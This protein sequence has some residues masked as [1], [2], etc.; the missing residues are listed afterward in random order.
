MWGVCMT[1]ALTVLISDPGPVLRERRPLAVHLG[2]AALTEGHRAALLAALG[3][4]VEANTSLRV[5][6]VDA[7]PAAAEG[8]QRCAKQSTFRCWADVLRGD[9]TEAAPLLFLANGIALEGDRLRVAAF[10]MDLGAARALLEGRT[11]E[12]AEE[13]E[14]QLYDRA[15]TSSV[16]AVRIG[17]SAALAKELEEML[18]LDLAQRL[19]AAGCAYPNGRVIVEA[20]SPGLQIELEGLPV[21]FSATEPTVIDG[22]REGQRA[23]SVQDPK[24]GGPAWTQALAITRGGEVRVRPVLGL[25]EP[26]DSRRVVFWSG[27]GVGTLGLGILAYS[28]LASPKA[29]E[30][31]VCVVC[32]GGATG[33]FAR[34]SDF[35]SEAGAPS[36]PLVGP[37]GYS[38]AAAGGTTALTSLLGAPEDFPWWSIVAGVAAFGLSYS[39]SEALD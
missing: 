35:W 11:G 34:T 10:L 8:S 20:D 13:L 27:I 7:L 38:L 29:T 15:I 19:E 6:L 18:T 23:L 37:L 14:A 30:L 17:D 5:V 24:G 25:S 22:V 31:D 12:E 9:L 28:L 3:R 32:E 36:G 26:S 33:R 39:V 21:G 1:L 4:M 16:R 2:G